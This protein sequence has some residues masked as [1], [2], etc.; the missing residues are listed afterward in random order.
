V[1]IIVDNDVVQRVLV[2]PD[3]SEFGALHDQLFG[4][5]RPIQR[6]IYGGKLLKEYLGNSNV[7]RALL[8]LDRAGRTISLPSEEV[9]REE[10]V[11]KASSLCCSNDT[12]IIALARITGVRVLVSKDQDLHQDFTN[13]KLLKPRGKVYQ[14]SSHGRL[15]HRGCRF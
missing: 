10:K 6:L 4:S 14:N 13:A 3:D 11:V 12:H 5:K 15:L 1:C 7:R 2:R 9:D 8:A